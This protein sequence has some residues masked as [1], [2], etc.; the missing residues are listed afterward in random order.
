MKVAVFI[1][2]LCMASAES[3]KEKI[4]NKFMGDADVANIADLTNNGEAIKVESCEGDADAMKIESAKFDIEKFTLTVTGNLQRQLMAGNV[5]AKILLGQATADATWQERTSRWFGF[6]MQRNTYNEPLCDH[7]ERGLRR[8]DETGAA[9]PVEAGAKKTLHFSLKRLPKAVAAGEYKFLVKAVDEVG[10]VACMN[11][12]I[13]VQRGANGQFFRRVQEAAAG[14]HSL[15][16]GLLPLLFM[17][18]V[19]L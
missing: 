13:V 11:G 16:A 14:A 4:Y 19:N 6:H 7:L 9:C 8:H 5:S 3:M 18:A 2:L 1:S 17:A 12:L 15:Y 10:S